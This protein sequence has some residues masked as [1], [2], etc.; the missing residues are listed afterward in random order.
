[1]CK[2]SAVWNSIGGE[3]AIEIKNLENRK[4]S[5]LAFGKQYES[6]LNLRSRYKKISE[7][8]IK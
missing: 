8:Y 7:N 1:V 4:K 3:N 6:K 5:V 2:N